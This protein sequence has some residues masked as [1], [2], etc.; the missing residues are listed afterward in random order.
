LPATCGI[1]QSIFPMFRHAACRCG[2]ARGACCGKRISTMVIG[3]PHCLQVNAHG[4]SPPSS[5]TIAALFI[6]GSI[7]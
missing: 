7:G 2:G 5:F 3:A 1:E 4:F 6:F